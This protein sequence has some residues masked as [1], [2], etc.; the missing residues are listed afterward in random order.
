MNGTVY[1]DDSDPVRRAR[2]LSAPVLAKRCYEHVQLREANCVYQIRLD[3]HV[4]KTPANAPLEVASRRYGVQMALEWKRQ[5]THVDPADMPYT[6]LANSAI[7]GVRRSA[8]CVVEEIAAYAQSDLVLYRADG[9][10]GLVALQ[11]RHWD[12]VLDY[13]QRRF[14]AHF[15]LAQGVMPA[16]QPPESLA[17]IHLAV[18]YFME[19]PLALAGLQV[20]SALTG[21]VLIA[22]STVEKA[23]SK[24]AAWTAAHVD[25][26]WNSAHWGEDAQALER[27]AYRWREFCAAHLAACSRE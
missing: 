18:R 27:R 8:P 25:E 21:S 9:P 22:L 14:Q 15:H 2:K 4:A 26:D 23:L 20:M 1:S 19:N 5:E 17:N 24:E 3:G 13:V 10:A 7:D 12:P 11:G 16:A 6:R